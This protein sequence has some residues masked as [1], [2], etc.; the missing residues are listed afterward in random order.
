MDRSSPIRAI[1][2]DSRKFVYGLAKEDLPYS[3][4]QCLLRIE[5]LELYHDM[6]EVE[7]KIK[8]KV[9]LM[10]LIKDCI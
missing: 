4:E 9:L 8:D 1:K 3:Y 2:D 10:R 6:L 5:T 7:I